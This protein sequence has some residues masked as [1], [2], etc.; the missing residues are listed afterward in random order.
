[1]T[2]FELARISPYLYF[3]VTMF[4]S[5]IISEIFSFKKWRYLEI[6]FR[7]HSRS[8][9]IAPLD[10]LYTT[11]YR[12]AVVSVGIL[13]HDLLLVGRCKWGYLVSRLATASPSPS[14][15]VPWR[16]HQLR[17]TCGPNLYGSRSQSQEE[18][19]R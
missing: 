5:G 2:L 4:V 7:G 3:I 13:C 17:E 6:W 10:R 15:R 1:M 18:P 12:S 8:L 16:I 14:P 11:C 9:K 19:L